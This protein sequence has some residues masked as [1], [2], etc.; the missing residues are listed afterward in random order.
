MVLV[1]NFGGLM[2][3]KT[4]CSERTKWFDAGSIICSFC[5]MFEAGN[6]EGMRFKHLLVRL[7][8]MMHVSALSVIKDCNNSA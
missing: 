4:K 6:D 5:A 3:S 1:S 2:T 7:V 8:N